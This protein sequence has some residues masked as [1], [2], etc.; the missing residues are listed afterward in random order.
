MKVPLEMPSHIAERSAGSWR[1]G[2]LQMHFAPEKGSLRVPFNLSL[3]R[4]RYCGQVSAWMGS[5]RVCAFLT[6]FI[7]IPELM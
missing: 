3:S 2:G 6:C 5:I 1:R 4:N 7:A